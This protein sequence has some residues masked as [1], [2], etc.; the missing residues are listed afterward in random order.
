[1]QLIDGKTDNHLWSE[2]YDRDWGDIFVIYTE[3]AEKVAAA[4]EAVITQEEEKIINKFP[5]TNIAAYDLFI[6]AK[7]ERLLYFQTYDQK[8]LKRSHDLLDKAIQMDPNYLMAILEKGAAYMNEGNYDSSFVYIDRVLAIDPD[9]SE[10][11]AIKGALYSHKK[12]LDLAIE[13]Y[14][15][16]IDLGGALWVHNALGIAYSINNELPKALP[17]FEKALESEND[18]FLRFVYLQIA[19]SYLH[20]GYYEKVAE[21]SQKAA[22][23]YTCGA[24]D[25]MMLAAQ[26]KGEFQ[27]IRQIADSLCQRAGCEQY[28]YRFTFYASLLLGEFEKAEQYYYSWQNAGGGIISWQLSLNYEIGYVLYQ[29][30]R[31][32]EAEKIFKEQI[33]R[34]ESELDK[35]DRNTYLN[36]ARIFAFRAEKKEALVYLKKY[37]EKGFKYGQHDFILIDPF[38]ESLRD[39]PEFKAIVRQAQ[40]EKAALRAQFREMEERG[41]LNL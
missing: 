33:K 17:H 6:R 38:F 24:I 28:C 13:N 2:E 25:P 36:L 31:K 41:E 9:F 22:D 29:L 35:E 34:L 40:E 10:A 32:E 30:G 16:A 18:G 39:D 11:Y 4:L 19:I 21:Y 5:T 27:K 1:V 23:L 3:I 14:L 15:K 12:K 7:H 26:A 20:L 8:N 37:A